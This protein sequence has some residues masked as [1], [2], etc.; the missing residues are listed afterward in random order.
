MK[1]GGAWQKTKDDGK[2]FISIVIDK[3]VKPLIITDDKGLCLFVNDKKTE[4][5][6]PDYTVHIFKREESKE[7]FNLSSNYS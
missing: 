5:K 2:T 6:H 3:E 1:I 7:D 4:P